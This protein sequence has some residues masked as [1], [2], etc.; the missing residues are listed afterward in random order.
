MRIKQGIDLTHYRF[1]LYEEYDE[2]DNPWLN[3]KMC[4]L[5][6][7][8][9]RGQNYWY[10]VDENRELKIYGSQPDGA[11]G[12]ILFDDIV[13]KMYKDGVFEEKEEQG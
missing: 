5:I 9:R 3:G 8:S 11:P 10:L 2:E 1:A 4:Y 13:L 12:S 7:H 6:G